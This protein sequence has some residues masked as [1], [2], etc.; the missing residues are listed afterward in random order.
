MFLFHFKDAYVANQK[1]L[2]MSL[3]LRWISCKQACFDPPWVH[4]KKGDV[5]VFRKEYIYI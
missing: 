4:K 3:D 2:L 1:H 5:S